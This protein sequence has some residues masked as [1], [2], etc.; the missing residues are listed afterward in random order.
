MKKGEDDHRLRML[1]VWHR[2][3]LF[4]KRGEIILALAET[5]TQ[6]DKSQLPLDFPRRQN[7]FSVNYTWHNQS[8]LL[9]SKPG[10]G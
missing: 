4:N 2:S 3:D 9:Q 10:T 5:I 6:I 7:Q 1:T 8:A